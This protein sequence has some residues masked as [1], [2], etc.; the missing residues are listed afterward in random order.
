MATPNPRALRE[1]RQ[2]ILDAFRAALPESNDLSEGQVKILL[3]A[4]GVELSDERLKG[5]VAAALRSLQIIEAS[6]RA[7]LQQILEQHPYVES[8]GAA[9]RHPAQPFVENCRKCLELG[10]YEQAQEE[11]RRTRS[12]IETAQ[13]WYEPRAPP[14]AANGAALLAAPMAADRQPASEEQVLTALQC[15]GMSFHEAQETWRKVMRLRCPEWWQEWARSPNHFE[16]KISK[17]SRRSAASLG[18]EESVLSPSAPSAVE[19]EGGTNVSKE[20]VSLSVE[21]VLPTHDLGLHDLWAACARE[22]HHPE[23]RESLE[24]LRKVL[25][26]SKISAS[27]GGKQ[28][29]MRSGGEQLAACGTQ[30]L[31]GMRVMLRWQ[32]GSVGSTHLA[33]LNGHVGVINS[34]DSSSRRWQVGFE[35]FDGHLDVAAEHLQARGETCPSKSERLGLGLSVA[36]LGCACVVK[37]AMDEMFVEQLAMPFDWLVTRVE[38]VLYF[39]RHHFRDFTHYD[40]VQVVGEHGFTS[41]RSAYHAFPHHD[42]STS[43]AREAFQRRAERM[44]DLVISCREASA[45]PLLLVR[46]CARSEELDQRPG[47][48]S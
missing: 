44:M 10:K 30:L 17:L 1:Q 26:G 33:Y 18:A 47:R 24:A 13:I 15:Q 14:I 32:P 40:D 29:A 9:S 12:V 2:R 8:G 42:L 43:T 36:S 22:W 39:F 19:G 37:Q 11:L 25:Q 38:G 7:Q 6:V 35:T 41:F 23:V 5:M 48:G 27:S 45:R 28:L 4:L 20:A 16:R 46:V 34:W 31:V 21:K 3:K